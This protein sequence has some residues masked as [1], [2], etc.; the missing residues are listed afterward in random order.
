VSPLSHYLEPKAAFRQGRE[1]LEAP[2][3]PAEALRRLLQSDAARSLGGGRQ[4][5]TWPEQRTMAAVG[6]KLA[7]CEYIVGACHKQCH[8]RWDVAKST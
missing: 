6:L 7:G 5:R 4:P 8:V 3:L 2:R 1:E